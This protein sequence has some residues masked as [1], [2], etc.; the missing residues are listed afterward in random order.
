MVIPEDF[1]FTDNADVHTFAES[2]AVLMFGTDWKNRDDL[3][4]SIPHPGC[5]RI[6]HADRDWPTLDVARTWSD[7]EVIYR[8]S[9]KK[10]QSRE[11]PE[12]NIAGVCCFDFDGKLRRLDH[13]LNG[14]VMNPPDGMPAT[15]KYDR[16]GNIEVGR[17][18]GDKGEATPKEI[19]ERIAQARQT[20]VA[21]LC[22]GTQ[23]VVALESSK[24]YH[25]QH[26]NAATRGRDS[27]ER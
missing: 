23:D 4:F 20:M 26:T 7:G 6:M 1:Q 5:R 27:Q 3:Q 24:F 11:D 25:Q 15:L 16:Q 13:F 2:R 21:G 22:N 9:C 10:N 12:P 8:V 18:V 19:A 17:Y 14:I